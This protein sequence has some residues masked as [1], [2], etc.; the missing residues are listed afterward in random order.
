MKRSTA[1]LM[2]V[3]AMAAAAGAPSASTDGTAVRE[4]VPTAQNAQTGQRQ[5][6][7]RPIPAAVT[8]AAS[9]AAAQLASAGVPFRVGQAHGCPWPG[10]RL[11]CARRGAGAARRMR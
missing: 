10:R 5:Q 3:A 6:S 1:G 2:L 9:F 7:E 8:R 4:V 11:A